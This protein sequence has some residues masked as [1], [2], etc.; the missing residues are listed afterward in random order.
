VVSKQE[1]DAYFVQAATLGSGFFAWRGP[2]QRNECP[3]K[4]SQNGKNIAEGNSCKNRQ[5]VANIL[6]SG[7]RIVHILRNLGL[8]NL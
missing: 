7:S 8:K 3:Q 2:T 4:Y 5:N 6:A 1:L